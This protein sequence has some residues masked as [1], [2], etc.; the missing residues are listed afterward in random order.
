MKNKRKKK[1]EKV[2]WFWLSRFDWG[3]YPKGFMK[4]LA[5]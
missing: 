5:S 3:A 1:K 2:Y 4:H